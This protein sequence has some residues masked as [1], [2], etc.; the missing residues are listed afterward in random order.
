MRAVAEEHLRL[1]LTNQEVLDAVRR[2]LP[3]RSTTLRSIRWYRNML[4]AE[5][6]IFAAPTMVEIRLRRREAANL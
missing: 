2:E 6:G 3:G 5:E 1:G 4:R